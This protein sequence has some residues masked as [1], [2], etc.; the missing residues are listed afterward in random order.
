[1]A[2]TLGADIESVTHGIRPRGFAGVC[3]QAQAGVLRVSISCTEFR[4]AEQ[5]FGLSATQTAQIR[6]NAW[7]YRFKK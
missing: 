4:L 2:D 3:G 7:D 1:M 6:Q 5:M